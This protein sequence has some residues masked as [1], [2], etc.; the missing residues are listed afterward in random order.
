MEVLVDSS[1][2]FRVAKRIRIANANEIE[3]DDVERKNIPC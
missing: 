2:V 1:L 3:V